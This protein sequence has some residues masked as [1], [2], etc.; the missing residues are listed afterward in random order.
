MLLIIGTL[1]GRGE[2]GMRIDCLY[3]KL[4]FYPRPSI[5]V[6]VGFKI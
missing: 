3:E 2:G 5:H 4:Y 6:V 1:R